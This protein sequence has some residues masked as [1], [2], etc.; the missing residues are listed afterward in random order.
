MSTGKY[1]EFA[2]AVREGAPKHS[3]DAAPFDAGHTQHVAHTSSKQSKQSAS[4]SCTVLSDAEHAPLISVIIP[5]CNVEKFL[6]QCISSILNQSYKNLE[7]IAINDGSTD[8]SLSVLESLAA[9]DTRLRIINKENEGYGATCNRGLSEARGKWISI[10]E[11]DD[12]IGFQMY[13]RMIQFA[14]SFSQPIDIVK[15]SFWRVQYWNDPFK[16]VIYKTP[17]FQGL[18]TSKKPVTIARIPRLLEGHPSIW[19]CLYSKAFLN[20]ENIRFPEYPGASWA[21]NPFMMETLLKAHALVYLNEAFYYYRCDL[22]ESTRFHDS[23]EKVMLPFERWQEMQEIIEKNHVID[24]RILKAH[25][26]RGFRYLQGAIYDDGWKNPLVQNGMR[27]MFEHMN[28][29]LV[30]HDSA[31]SNKQK[32]LFF[33]E[34]GAPHKYHPTPALAYRARLLRRSWEYFRR[35]GL[36]ALRDKIS[37]YQEQRR[38]Q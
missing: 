6:T 19:T 38:Y 35:K 9:L 11:P 21:D 16:E 25:I 28:P 29:S 13:A 20:R 7:V 23:P 3:E 14:E 27:K 17:D 31:L 5:V 22:P 24:K 33:T 12:F 8:G 1:Q 15:T 26:N 18:K 4:H 36:G 10:I 2:P 34:T 32:R 37:R 30:L